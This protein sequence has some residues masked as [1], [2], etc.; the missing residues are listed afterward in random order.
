VQP[1]DNRIGIAPPQAVSFDYNPY[2]PEIFIMVSTERGLAT[3][4]WND[5]TTYSTGGG[6]GFWVDHPFQRFPLLLQRLEMPLVSWIDQPSGR[7]R[8]NGFL[9]VLDQNEN[10]VFAT[11]F[12]ELPIGVGAGFGLDFPVPPNIPGAVMN[13]FP[14]AAVS[15]YE[16]RQVARINVFGSVVGVDSDNT[17]K[18]LLQEFWWDGQRW[19]WN[20]HPSPDEDIRDIR[21]GPGSFIFPEN[22]NYEQAFLFVLTFA[23]DTPA[24]TAVQLYHWTFKNNWQW[25]NLDRPDD[26]IAMRSPVAVSYVNSTTG[27][28]EVSV[29]ISGQNRITGIWE[30]YERHWNG[31]DIDDWEDWRNWGRPPSVAIE[32]DAGF[33]NHGF[34]M[35]CS[36][37]WYSGRT[38]R[39]NLFGCT[40]VFQE[41]SEF[42]QGGQLIEFWWDG[43][44]WRWGSQ[45]PEEAFTPVRIDNSG[46]M[47]AVPLE[48]SSAVVTQK[49]SRTHISVFG[50]DIN[51]TIWER[52]WDSHTNTAW[53]WFQH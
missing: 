46:F 4:F 1:P 8:V 2:S 22:N 9:S 51:G 33:S 32:N 16:G 48:V 6:W 25:H 49:D 35:T 52:F 10:R 28:T 39:I 23:L 19:N 40:S 3:S 18:A 42:F 47:S 44:T 34:R 7:F 27:R 43:N 53:T 24:D 45:A 29:F 50:L 15:W 5:Q 14:L 30:L 17:I 41:P 12:W 13:L 38:L 11:P 37:V 26:V 36:V 20:N 21:F 31:E